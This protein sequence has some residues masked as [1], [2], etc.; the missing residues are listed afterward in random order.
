MISKQWALNPKRLMDSSFFYLDLPMNEANCR[1]TPRY[2][3]CVVVGLLEHIVLKM[4][5]SSK[6]EI[7]ACAN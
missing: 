7:S 2:F 6:R 1:P 3:G 5:L 4:V